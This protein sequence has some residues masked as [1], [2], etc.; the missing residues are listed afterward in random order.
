MSPQI[1]GDAQLATQAKSP[2]LSDLF[3]QFL[4]IGA[5]S[6]GGGIIPTNVSSWLRSASGS[7]LMSLWPIWLSVRLCQA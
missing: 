2:D 1:Q 5:V 3:I 4:I 7:A 6:F